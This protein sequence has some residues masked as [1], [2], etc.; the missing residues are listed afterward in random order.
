[1]EDHKQFKEKFNS[2]SQWLAKAKARFAEISD[3]SG[4]RAEL[5]ER[6]EKAQVCPFQIETN[7]VKNERWLVR[8]DNI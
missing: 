8:Q 3:A 1:M 5:E 2:C 6:L 7:E 4:S